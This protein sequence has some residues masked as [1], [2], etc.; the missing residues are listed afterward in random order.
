MLGTKIDSSEKIL[1]KRG[2]KTYKSILTGS[3]KALSHVT[4]AQ[5]CGS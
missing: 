4:V 1:D 5:A 2:N 3:A